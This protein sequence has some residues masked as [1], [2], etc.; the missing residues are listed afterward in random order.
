MQK[1]SVQNIQSLLGLVMAFSFLTPE[2]GAFSNKPQQSAGVEEATNQG[3]A[4]APP[5][6]SPKT[7]EVAEP[8]RVEPSVIPSESSTPEKTPT[9][10][11]SS[12]VQPKA[13]LKAP[14]PTA[15]APL[16][17]T[18]SSQ[19]EPEKKTA[20]LEVRPLPALLSEVESKYHSGQTLR[21]HFEQREFIAS[22]GRVKSTHGTIEIKRPDKLRWETTAP[23]SNLLVSDG[24]KF[25]FYTPPF[26]EGERGQIIEKKAS[27]V[28]SKLAQTL[29]SGAFSVARDMKIE[30]IDATHFRLIPSRGSAGSV[31]S[32]EITVD[33]IRK[34]II[35]VKLEH[36]GGNRADISLSKIEIGANIPDELFVFI[37]PTNT[38]RIDP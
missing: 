20:V 14:T 10:I 3:S 22:L 34:E 11:A 5:S 36:R 33:P 7:E 32:A 9:P 38:D 30:T 1:S 23:D 24:K 15:Q 31:R 12:S 17:E 26:D 27:Q 2:A 35:Q 25:W 28:Q 19:S 37:V 6:P 4:L 16:K 29:I 8:P 13:P 18:Q 21:A